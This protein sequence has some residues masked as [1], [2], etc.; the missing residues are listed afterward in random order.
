MH[1]NMSKLS[2]RLRELREEKKLLQKDIANLLNITASAY[3]YYEQGKREP[4][5]H[6]VKSLADFYNVS[7]DYLL[8]RTN[9]RRTEVQISCIENSL[10]AAIDSLS[11][12]SKKELEKYVQLLKL[13]D[14]MENINS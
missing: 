3:G 5:T 4:D 11:P 7:T 2:I 1:K 9:N 10:I 6:T 8:G 13:K 12:Q 14:L